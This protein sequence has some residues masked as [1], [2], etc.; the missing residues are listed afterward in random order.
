MCVFFV[1]FSCFAFSDAILKSDD[2]LIVTA[3]SARVTVPI[4]FTQ[5]PVRV[6]QLFLLHL[7]N[8]FAS[9]PT[10]SCLLTQIALTCGY[11]GAAVQTRTTYEV[12][13]ATWLLCL[14]LFVT[15]GCCFWLSFLVDITKDVVHA[16]PYCGKVLGRCYRI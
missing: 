9:S 4:R 1:A 16:C 10:R 13:T 5:Y 8:S 3:P 15:T 7:L 11:C 6:V 12:G 2:L 14:A